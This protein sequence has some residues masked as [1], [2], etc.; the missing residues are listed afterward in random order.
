MFLEI[1]LK[2]ITSVSIFKTLKSDPSLT[3]ER[4]SLTDERGFLVAG[5]MHDISMLYNSFYKS[6]SKASTVCIQEI[7]HVLL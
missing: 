3:V 4:P 6:F 7:I 5:G 2:L 1:C